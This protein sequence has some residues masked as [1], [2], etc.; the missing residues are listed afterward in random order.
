R[1]RGTSCRPH[2]RAAESTRSPGGR[3]RQPVPEAPPGLGARPYPRCAAP[4]RSA[5]SDRSFRQLQKAIEE[6]A[7]VVR[8]G[9]GLRVVLDG[10]AGD[11]LQHEAFDSAVIEVE[12]GELRL[13][14]VRLP[15]N[16]LVALDGLVAAGAQDRE[17]MILRGDVDPARLQVLDRM[18]GAAMPEGELVGLEADGATEQLVAEAD[19]DDRLLVGRPA[20]LLDD[21]VARSRVARPIREEYQVRL[22]GEYA[23]GRR[24]VR[25]EGHPA[26]TLLELA[27][28]RQLDAGID[29][30]NVWT[31]AL[32]L[33]RFAGRDRPGEVRAVHGGLGGH[34]L[35]RLGLVE[36]RREDAAP[37]RPQVADVAN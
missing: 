19:A 7:G 10:A 18:V 27:D 14:E 1:G 15:A 28:D 22:P 34:S 11:V 23:L 4:P 9:A 37:H 33:N 26:A 2:R 13:A 3:P 16:R 25:Q 6:V 17:A 5:T 36:L 21:V 24:V 12:V 32:D 8:A 20:D 35:P 29:P 31:V 30:Y